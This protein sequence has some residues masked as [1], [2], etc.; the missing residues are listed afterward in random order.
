SPS[1]NVFVKGVGTA[2][3]RSEAIECRDS[4]RGSEVAIASASNQ[5][6]AQLHIH[7]RSDGREPVVQQPGYQASF[8]RRTIDAACNGDP[9]VRSHWGERMNRRVKAL[10]FLSAYVS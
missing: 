7:V 6:L 5:G 1:L 8:H 4:H 2:A 9:G 10:G 3:D